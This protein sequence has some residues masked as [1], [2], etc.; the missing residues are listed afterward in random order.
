MKKAT[1][2]SAFSIFL[3]LGL[4]FNE[5]FSNPPKKKSSLEKR[6]KKQNQIQE[7]RRTAVW[8]EGDEAAEREVEFVRA[9]KE[10]GQN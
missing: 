1:L 3:L 5:G 6:M 7:E 2:V 8:T 9:D 4:T 10:E